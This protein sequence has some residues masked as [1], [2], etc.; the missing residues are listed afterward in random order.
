MSGEYKAERVTATTLIWVAILSAVLTIISTM[1]HAFLVA[2][3][4]KRLTLSIGGSRA[5]EEIGMPFISGVT[6]GYAITAFVF[7]L[8]SV[9]RFF[10]PF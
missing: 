8:I 6:A 2:W 1:W 3:V 7:G 5:Y 4:L 10:V 9:I